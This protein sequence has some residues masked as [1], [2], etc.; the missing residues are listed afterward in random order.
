VCQVGQKPSAA[1][2]ATGNALKLLKVPPSRLG[3]LIDLRQDRLVEP[4]DL[5][6]L[7][8]QRKVFLAA[9]SQFTEQPSETKDRVAGGLALPGS[10]R[11][12]LI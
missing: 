7:G 9:S 8:G 10:D 12:S 1:A 3:V 11:V 5:L 6:D 2:V 4:T